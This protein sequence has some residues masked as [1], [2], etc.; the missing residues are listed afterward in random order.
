MQL[1]YNQ[2]VQAIHA[3]PKGSEK[4]GL[5][6]MLALLAAL[7]N[8]EKQLQFVHVVGTN[9]KGSAT[10]LTAS[11]L[12]QAGY[13]VGR[14]VSPYILDFRERFVINGTMITEEEL[15]E[16]ANIVLN[17]AEEAKQQTGFAPI[18]FEIVTAIA[19]YW[20]AKESCDIVCMEAGIGGRLDSTNA[21]KNTLVAYVMHMGLDHQSI[22]GNTIAEI[23]KEKAGVF[24]NNCTVISYPAQPVEALLT[25]QRE[26]KNKSCPLVLPLEA[27]IAIEEMSLAKTKMHYKNYAVTLPFGGVHQAFNTAVVIE[28]CLALRGKGYSISDEDIVNGIQQTTFPARIEVLS[29]APLVILDGAHNEDGVIALTDL[30]T[31]THEKEFTAVVGMV[32]DKDNATFLNILAPYVKHIIFTTPPIYKALPAEMLAEMAGN[33]YTQIEIEP[34]VASA[35]KKAM[36]ISDKVLVTGSL[37]LAAE[38]RGE[39]LKL[40]N[41]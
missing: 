31:R 21:V 24:K 28:G 26:A 18:E 15:T 33:K 10:A 11:V 20:F 32:K 16:V 6:N 37:Y 19:L 4:K 34:D 13:K 23:T 14:N 5:T 25:I 8:P 38:A 7:G 3:R 22:L 29:E 12:Q 39:L 1:T 9:G 2:T 40:L 35:V 36:Q 27:D 30:L 17:A 41:Q